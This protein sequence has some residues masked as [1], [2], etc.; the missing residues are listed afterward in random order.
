MTK[1]RRAPTTLL[2]R[3]HALPIRRA[4][5]DACRR[6]PVIPSGFEP[7]THSLEGCCS[8]QL[9]Y[10]TISSSRAQSRTPVRNS[11][12]APNGRTTPPFCGGRSGE[13]GDKGNEKIK[14]RNPNDEIIRFYG[15]DAPPGPPGR[16]RGR[17]N[18]ADFGRT[19]C[20]LGNFVYLCRLS[21]PKRV[22]RY[23]IT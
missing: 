9:S 1:K 2:F 23:S 19:A 17:T 13:R 3:F 4:A 22:G 7:E 20:G 11:A 14:N 5:K 18:S 10:G 16:T 6:D 21:I 12:E 8:I 15:P